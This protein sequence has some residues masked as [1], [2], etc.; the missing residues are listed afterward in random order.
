MNMDERGQPVWE[1]RVDLLLEV[2]SNLA[3]HVVFRPAASTLRS[4]GRESSVRYLSERDWA[5]TV[6]SGT[7]MSRRS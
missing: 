2:G 7:T 4:L 6:Y 1:L 5:L 3:Q